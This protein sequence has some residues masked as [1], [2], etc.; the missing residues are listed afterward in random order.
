MTTTNLTEQETIEA[1]TPVTEVTDQPVESTTD[2][3]SDATPETKLDLLIKERVGNFT[4]HISPADLKYV[5]NLL[6]NKIEWKGPNEAYLLLMSTISITSILTE[7][8]DRTTDRVTVDISLSTIE[9]INFFLNRV[10]GKG[11]E[12]AHR[13]FAISM[14]IR[15]ALEHI[16]SLDDL[17]AAEKAVNSTD[18]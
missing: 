10:T 9:A 7:L 5:K 6:T 1:F 12:S 11:E 16:K 17:I 8:D 13:I 18:K 2:P 14:L 15:P 3:T 4:L